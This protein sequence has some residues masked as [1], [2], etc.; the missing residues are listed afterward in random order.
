MPLQLRFRVTRV[1]PSSER[2]IR[3]REP[4]AGSS[5]RRRSVTTLRLKLPSTRWERDFVSHR[6]R[7]FG[8]D[9]VRV[10]GQSLVDELQRYLLH[11]PRTV[12]TGLG[13]DARGLR[14][15]L[16]D[17]RGVGGE[18]FHQSRQRQFAPWGGTCI[19]STCPPSIP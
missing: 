17:L 16:E 1:L 9:P 10:E 14:V 18:D 7:S 2:S 15:E 13:G 5:R 3:G 6:E 4:R 11:A 19:S 12:L 8:E